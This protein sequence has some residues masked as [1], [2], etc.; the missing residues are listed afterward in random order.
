MNGSM[1][2]VDWLIVVLP[3]AFV[4]GIA[5]DSK[6]YAKGVVNYLAAGRVAGR[7]VLTV[8]DMTTGIG[9]V[10]LMAYV[11][12]H[13]KTGFGV[14]FWN[15]ATIPLLIFFALSGFCI[16]RFR[17]SKA[18]SNGQ[19]LEMR[20]SRSLR[21]I[22][23]T[24]R[25]TAELLTNCIGPA[26]ATQFFIYFLGIPHTIMLG[27][28]VIQ[29]YPFLV[30]VI[31]ILALIVILPGG[32][33][34][35]L[36]T[37]GIQGLVC[38][39]VFVLI[40]GYV[41]F[42]FSWSEQ[43]SPVLLDRV[44]GE[45]LM[46]PFDVSNLRD[47]NV[48]TVLIIVIAKIYNTAS[49]AGNDVTAS[50]RT[51]HEQ[52][53]AGVLGVWRLGI[54][55]VLFIMVSM[56]VLTVMNHASLAPRAHEIRQALSEKVIA[57]VIPESEQQREALNQAIATIPLQVHEIGVDTPLSHVQ[58]LDTVYMDVVKLGLGDTPEGNAHFQKFRTLY[59][60]MMMPLG[61][62]QILPAGLMGLFCLLAL[63]LMLSTDDSRI[64]NAASASVQ[65]LV[66]P[67]QKK[68]MTPHQH[69]RLVK[70]MAVLVAGIFFMGSVF[71]SQMD[72]IN[73]FITI[74]VSIW[75]G[76]AA[77]IMVFGLYSR[78]GNTVGAYGAIIFGSGSAVTGAIL[79]RKW[80]DGVYPFL[81]DQGWVEGVG[82]FLAAI[83]KPLNPYVVWEMN[84]VKFPI[85]SYELSF[86]ALLFGTIAYVT[87]SLLANR[88]PFNLDRLLH[89]GKYNTDGTA[90]IQS[91]WTWRS[92]G[93]K[94]VGITSDYTRGDKIIAWGVVGYTLVYQLI[95][96]FLVVL[97][98]NLIDPWPL[99][100]WSS[101]Y[102]IIYFVTSPLI[103]I[104]TA[105]WFCWG[106]VRDIR[107]LFRDLAKRVDN[108]LDDGRVEGD[109]ALSD[110][111]LLKK[112]EEEK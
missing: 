109:V 102:F 86:I 17:E 72:Y 68:A 79:Q 4:L 32:R 15:T 57:Q 91:K 42:Q 107:Q 112:D 95:L 82:S 96:S 11:E 47:F 70:W 12:S 58:N 90:E 56:V 20:Y 14:M 16:Y 21:I 80:A 105:I 104:I 52:K 8:G 19:F 51:P 23:S 27:E 37:D 38:Y 43:I 97:I 99:S 73:M 39:P 45:S 53:M 74:M 98:W 35:L 71:F 100:W 106:G 64:F 44:P 1:H 22:A 60:Q 94:L 3:V 89:R 69:I 59:H 29:T 108:P 31:L 83:S 75:L 65:D 101:Y 76:A 25:V 41:M 48:V 30:G 9:I 6:R 84:P 63:L 26:I 46:N 5:I 28:V 87:G 10:T 7:Y 24:I 110:L 36:I 67:F 103:G 2:W 111:D 18:I 93:G 40:V 81:Q 33:I 54:G 34:A 55:L 77:P 61:L 92:A 78:L 50:G 13:Y 85:N 88:K 62:R 49:F 66:I